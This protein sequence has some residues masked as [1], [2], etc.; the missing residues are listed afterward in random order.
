MILNRG[1]SDRARLIAPV[2]L[3][4]AA[5][6]IAGICVAV[7]VEGRALSLAV[8]YVWAR[9]LLTAGPGFAFLGLGF[10]VLA[11]RDYR[12]IRAAAAAETALGAFR[13]SE[14]R[15]RSL[16]E[17]SPYAIYVHTRGRFAYVNAAAVELFGAVSEEELLGT[18]VLERI[19][20]EFRQAVSQR[21]NLLAEMDP[22]AK[23]L[24]E[25]RS[26]YVRLDGGLVDVTVVL[27]PT[28]FD[29]IPGAQV[30]VRDETER[31]AAARALER[32]QLLA[33][34]AADIV[35]FI[36]PDGR[37]LDV[38]RAAE[39]AYG[40]TRDELLTMNVA[41]LRAP[42]C[43]S[44]LRAQL[45]QALAGGIRFE[46]QN[47]R[48]DGTIFDVEVDSQSA[49]IDGERIVVSVS[50][51]ITERV[52]AEASIRESAA[53]YRGI[54]ESLPVPLLLIDATGL[55]SFANKPAIRLLG[56]R[57]DDDLI[58]AAAVEFLGP[59][60]FQ[61]IVGRLSE[62][63]ADGV[64]VRMSDHV[65]LSR[66]GSSLEVDYLVSQG[67]L[68]GAW[69]VQVIIEPADERKNVELA[70]RRSLMDTVH[71]MAQM[72]EARD[73][74]TAGHQNR[75]QHVAVAIA[76]EMGLDDERVT[77]VSLA[78]TV[79]DL[80]KMN[81]PAEILSKPGRLSPEEFGLIKLHPQY[82][83]DIVAD[84]PFP[85]PIADIVL[86][87]HERLDGSGYPRGLKGDAIC[88]EARIIAV[89][90][91]VEAVSSHRPYRAAL[92]LEAALGIMRDGS[93]TLYDPLVVESCER[94]IANSE[95]SL[96]LVE[97]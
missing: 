66:G 79:H 29:S 97:A 41:Q 17:A 47:V 96:E 63:K 45:D 84:I 1:R 6:V 33:E 87:H 65:I 81:I 2:V 95:S 68:S 19:D 86:Q 10:G 28:V 61:E 72:V 93:G 82:G 27:V 42:G 37:C 44:G 74:Y 54:I 4:L 46:A 52:R 62:T 12:D 13:T 31:T 23:P 94:A 78:A 34:S 43:V 57:G 24:R 77:A 20:T 92:G 80:G 67:A 59:D 5:L 18:P 75:V 21:I 15:Y 8:R 85:W 73:P 35:F 22:A 7:D 90:D 14:N 70:L 53:R 3:C 76:R 56:A 69:T 60:S 91:M 58:G 48:A 64:V 36:G 88:L 25:I 26:R 16:V 9:H 71:A 38:N 40:Y 11:L 49:V 50:R 83:Y 39:T 51:D 89:A 30:I 32:Y 55:I